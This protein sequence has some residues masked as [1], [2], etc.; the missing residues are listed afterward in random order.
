MVKKSKGQTEMEGSGGGLFPAVEGHSLR[1]R[2]NCE[3]N[4]K[5]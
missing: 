5:K 1:T 4:A 3:T 2:Y